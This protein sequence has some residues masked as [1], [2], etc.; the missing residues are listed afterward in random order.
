MAPRPA[1]S[2]YRPAY[3]I[4]RPQPRTWSARIVAPIP[5]S[6]VH[7]DR[8]NDHRPLVRVGADPSVRRLVAIVPGSS[9]S[10]LGPRSLVPGSHRSTIRAGAWDRMHASAGT[11]PL[12]CNTLQ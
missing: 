2:G 8:L 12:T 9:V 11:L 6:R 7:S 3:R 10:T 5:E 4:T 1:S